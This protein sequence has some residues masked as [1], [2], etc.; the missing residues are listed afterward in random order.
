[1]R[2]HY[3]AFPTLSQVMGPPFEAI[4]K[5]KREYLRRAGFSV[6]GPLDACDGTAVGPTLQIW[7]QYIPRLRANTEAQ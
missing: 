3:P 1:M 4:L 6:G 2:S 7:A 5:D